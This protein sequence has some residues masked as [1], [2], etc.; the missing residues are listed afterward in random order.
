LPFLPADHSRPAEE[1]GRR[2]ELARSRSAAE[3]KKNE[4]AADYQ[5]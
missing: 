1:S 3:E 4:S 2:A 5:T